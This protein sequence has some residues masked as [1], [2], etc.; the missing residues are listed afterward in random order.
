MQTETA[1]IGATAQPA[2]TEDLMKENYEEDALQLTSSD[3]SAILRWSKDISSDINLS[4][5]LRRLTEIATENSG[6]QSS[7]VV[8]AREVGDYTVATRCV[9]VPRCLLCHSNI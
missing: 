3:L 6:A 4:S 9:D 7:C 5:A 2:S 1:I 8:I